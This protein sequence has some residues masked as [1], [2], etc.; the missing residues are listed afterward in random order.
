MHASL[1]ENN[2]RI[3][4][5]SEILMFPA[6]YS[7]KQFKPLAKLLR[8]TWL[9]YYR[10]KTGRYIVEERKTLRFLFDINNS[11]DKWTLAFGDY[12][13]EQYSE[14][15][16][17][18]AKLKNA[19]KRRMLFLDI[20]AHWGWYG[21]MAYKS[22]LFDRII[23]FEP[24][25]TNMGQLQ[26]NLFLN[27]LSG[28]I[29]AVQAAVSDANGFLQFEAASAD[30]DHRTTTR[31]LPAT[32]GQQGKIIRVPSLALDNWLNANDEILVLKIDVEGHEQSVLRGAATTL[33]RND[34]LIQ[35]EV[36]PQFRE[37][38]FSQLGSLGYQPVWNFHDDFICAK[39]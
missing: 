15:F 32:D 9:G 22:K 26:A 21:L 38:V 20:G 5:A 7:A 6:P 28:N 19:L 23:C 8:A 14:L 36:F 33:E 4:D 29:E 37:A 31:V 12:E 27:R 25:P 2:R 34:C 30:Q 24:D 10:G 11:M 39:V 13:R 3:S 16:D 1:S 18:A 35:I 17:Q